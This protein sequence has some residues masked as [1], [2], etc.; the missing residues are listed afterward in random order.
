MRIGSAHAHEG[1]QDAQCKK[2]VA[3][4]GA[5]ECVVQPSFFLK[6]L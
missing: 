3:N 5:D 2:R 4:H 1:E 6:S